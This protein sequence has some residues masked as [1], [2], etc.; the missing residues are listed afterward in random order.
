M[1]E[2]MTHRER[3]LSAVS[4]REPDLLPIDVGGHRDSSIHTVAYE[5]L[6]EHLNMSFPTV[7]V[8]RMQQAAR[9]DEEVLQ[10]LDVDTRGVYP[11]IPD[12]SMASDLS[13]ETWIDGWGVVRHKP[14]GSH[15]YDLKEAPLAG[16]I[17]I[18]DI[19]NYSWPDP[20]D[21][22]IIRGL[23]EKVKQAR[24][25][26]DFAV[27]MNLPAPIV[28]ISQ[29]L[30]GFLDWYIDLAVNQ[31]LMESLLDAVL[32][33][34][35]AIVHNVLSEVGDIID[36]AMTADDLGAQNSLQFSPE[37][38]RKIFKPRLAK[39]FNTVHS[40]TKAK[41]LFHTCGSVYK[42]IGDLIDIGI[43]VL[44]PVQPKASNMDPGKLK[45]EFGKRIAFWG[46]IDT[47]EVMWR[48]TPAEVR[49][50][51]KIRF[52]QLGEGGGW[53]LSPAHNLQPDVP[54]GNI[55]ELYRAAREI[56][57]YK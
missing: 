25:R 42:I 39:F 2:K 55:I 40:L 37:I 1:A 12:K 32:D 53:V 29:Y 16:D 22:G 51:V 47:Q 49:E 27:V 13:D 26:A 34:N 36:I 41:L 45:K 38:F 50:E 18:K 7:F 28:H 3:V 33:I 6:K 35:L 10:I 48:G 52:R 31:R 9:L 54:V 23:R 56:G 11:G 44:N 8:D 20:H 15:Y 57:R 17:S 4:L 5:R 19:L 43:D 24:N 21:P 14:E 46:A 30:R